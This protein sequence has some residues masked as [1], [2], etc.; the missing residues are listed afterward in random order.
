MAY[1]ERGQRR[2]EAARK[3][4]NYLKVLLSVPA[5]VILLYTGS[6]L[7]NHVR[8][9]PRGVETVQD[10]YRRYGNPPAVDSIFADG[11]KYYRITGDI[12]APL[13]FPKGNPIYVFDDTGRLIDWTGESLADPEFVRKWGNVT[14]EKM[15]VAYFLEKFPPN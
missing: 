14:N 4:T 2:V 15:S 13:G 9:I 7:Y 8:V 11:R 12:P 5:V 1:A 6:V 3:F 10:F